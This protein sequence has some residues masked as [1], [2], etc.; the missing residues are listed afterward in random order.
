MYLF[1]FLSKSSFSFLV[2][3]YGRKIVELGGKS[4]VDSLKSYM[5]GW[6]KYC[7]NWKS[8]VDD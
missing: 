3:D 6:E 8:W 5:D 4:F 2:E 1:M 7:E